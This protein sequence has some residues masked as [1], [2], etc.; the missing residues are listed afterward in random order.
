MAQWVKNL[1]YK[2]KILSLSSQHVCGSDICNPRTGI[3][4]QEDP[5]GLLSSQ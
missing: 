5:G 4:R 1:L 2:D 3:G